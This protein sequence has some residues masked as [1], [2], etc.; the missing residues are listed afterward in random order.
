M[1]CLSIRKHR[2]TKI[3]VNVVAGRSNPWANFQVKGSKVRRTAAYDVGSHWVDITFRVTLCC[4][5]HIA[6]CGVTYRVEMTMH[7]R[8]SWHLP[9]RRKNVFT[10]LFRS[11]FYVFNLFSTFYLLKKHCQMQSMNMQKSNEKYPQKCLSN[12]FNWFC[13]VAHTARYLTYLLTLRYVLKFDN[14]PMSDSVCEDNRWIHGKCRQRFYQTCTNVF[15]Y[16]NV[17]LLHLLYDLPSCGVTYRMEMTMSERRSCPPVS[18][19]EL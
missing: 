5:W 8:R 14:S 3:G 1:V 16:L 9:H 12:D 15:F 13:Y 18:T 4:R 6:S 19:C 7:E 2:K 17:T 11:R 10:F